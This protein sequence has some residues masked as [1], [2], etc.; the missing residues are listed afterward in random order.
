MLRICHPSHNLLTNY[1]ICILQILPVNFK[2]QSFNSSV[3]KRKKKKKTSRKDGQMMSFS[4]KKI[5]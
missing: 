5:K 1:A 3:K 4:N 2:D